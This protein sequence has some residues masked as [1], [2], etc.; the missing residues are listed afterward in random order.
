M[1]AAQDSELVLAYREGDERAGERLVE[2]YYGKV[3]SFCRSKAPSNAKDVTQRSFLAC[4]E[5]LEHLRDPSAFRKFLFGVVCNQLRKHYR[6]SRSEGERLDFGS[7]SSID[8]D[9]TP[10]RVM[11]ARAEQRLL[12]EGFRR[13]PLE[14]QIVLELFYWEDMRGSDIAE[15]LSIPL[16]TVKDRI[17]RGRKL[18]EK[19]L[20]ELDAPGVVLESTVS[21]LS[22]WARGLRESLSILDG[23]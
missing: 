21:D 13:I 12:L 18:L 11:A 3:L 15:V 20:T 7:V 9:P 2:R 17:R 8:L 5:R 23:C 14:H 22:S 4:F 10:S 6:D 1:S 16:G 19:A